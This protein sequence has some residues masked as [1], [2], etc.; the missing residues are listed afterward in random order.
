MK[1][2]VQ[3][4]RFPELQNY[5]VM[6]IIYDE[7]T[8]AFKDYNC[9]IRIVHKLEELQNEGI[10]FLSHGLSDRSDNDVYIKISQ[11]CPDVLFYCWY[12]CNQPSYVPYDDFQPFKYIIYTGNNI[13]KLPTVPALINE[14]NN[15][16]TSS[17]FCPLKLRANEHPDLVG[18]YPRNVVRDYCFMGGGYKQHWVPSEFTGIYHRVIYDNYL[19][20]DTRRE[21]YLSSFFAFG[22]HGEWPIDCGSISQRVFEGMAY[23]CIVLC[24][25]PMAE[26][27]TDGIVVT[28]HSKDDLIEK[29]NFYKT[30][31]ELVIQK[32]QKG[33]EWVK[34][35][36]TNRESVRILLE[37]AKSLYNLD[38]D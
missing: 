35:Y 19:P 21:I 22:F 4:P 27:I 18:T 37:K 32:Q 17:K 16:Q 26:Q 11:I 31:P 34:K 13:L 29:M 2:L 3:L 23:G 12:W 7:L 8:N 20:Y 10:I 5:L 36:G 33:Y 24:D 14:Y 15:Y 1:R 38:F 30:H 6:N 9:E 28:V 25:N